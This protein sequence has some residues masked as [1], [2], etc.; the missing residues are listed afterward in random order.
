MSSLE[1][2]SHYNFNMPPRADEYDVMHY[3]NQTSPAMVLLAKQIQAQSYVDSR[4][5][6]SD[7]LVDATEGAKILSSD[8]DTPVKIE[9][10][11]SRYRTEYAIAV[12]KDN[13]DLNP[14]T[15]TMATWKKYYAP[16]DALPAYQFCKPHLYPIGEMYLRYFDQDPH[17]Q[18]VEIEALAKTKNAKSRAIFELIRN[19]LQ[20]A[21]GEGE[22][23]YFSIVDKT[24]KTFVENWGPTAILQLGEPKRLVHPNVYED[25]RL[26]PAALDVD[27]FLRNMANDILA[28]GNGHVEKQLASFIFFSEGLSNNQLGEELVQFKIEALRILQD[29]KPKL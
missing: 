16:L 6:K 5:V 29:K 18:L 8:I 13:P 28:P 14:L 3:D 19:E 17:S 21:A 11:S 2:E 4:F 20:R 26:V 24:F 9:V 7:A 15:G 25:V 12:K 1:S 10:D 22:V 23:W 27:R